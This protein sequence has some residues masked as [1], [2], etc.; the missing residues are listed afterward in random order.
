MVLRM[1]RLMRVRN[2]KCLRS[3]SCV[4]FPRDMGFGG[5]MS[6]VRPPMI[7]EKAGDPKGLQEGFQFQEHLILAA[8]KDVCEDSAAPV[9]DSVPEPAWLLLAAHKAPHFI[10]FGVLHSTDA[11]G[12]AIGA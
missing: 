7:R 12:H 10:N 1:R 6:C 9:V 5:Q 2:V 11:D 8:T 3:I 4:A